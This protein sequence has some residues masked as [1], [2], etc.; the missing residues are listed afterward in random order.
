MR[1][2]FKFVAL[3]QLHAKA[4]QNRLLAAV[5]GGLIGTHRLGH[6]GFGTF[7]P[8]TTLAYRNAL[9]LFLTAHANG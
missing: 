1:K 5:D 6:F 9:F 2:I 3:A 4:I 8:K 7:P